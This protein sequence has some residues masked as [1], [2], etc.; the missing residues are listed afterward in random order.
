M[1]PMILV[2]FTLDKERTEMSLNTSHNSD[3][4]NISLFQVEH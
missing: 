2:I 3:V 4:D 1:K